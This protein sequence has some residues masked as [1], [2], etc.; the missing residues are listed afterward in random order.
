M[1]LTFEGLTEAGGSTY[2]VAAL[3]DWPVGYGCG[4]KASVLLYM[5]FSVR[6]LEYRH[7]ALWLASMRVSDPRNQKVEAIIPL[8]ALSSYTLSFLPYSVGVI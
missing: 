5:D 6:L 8:P 2:K 1:L 7:G 3:H 4:L